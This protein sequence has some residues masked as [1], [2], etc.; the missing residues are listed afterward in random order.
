MILLSGLMVIPLLQQTDSRG[1]LSLPERHPAHA[2][3]LG[4]PP[5]SI[6]EF[7]ADGFILQDSPVAILSCSRRWFN[8]RFHPD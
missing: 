8:C 3:P 7:F 4:K 2:Q 1:S 6:E 5:S